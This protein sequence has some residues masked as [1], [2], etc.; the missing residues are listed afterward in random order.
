[1]NVQK[2]NQSQSKHPSHT[3]VCGSL[4]RSL[5]T[6]AVWCAQL[7]PSLGVGVGGE[8]E[9]SSQSDDGRDPA[10]ASHLP[11]ML[12]CVPQNSAAQPQS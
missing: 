7:Q 1:M 2:H 12:L 6:P 10:P 3:P 5:V 8:T 11:C 9:C 4:L